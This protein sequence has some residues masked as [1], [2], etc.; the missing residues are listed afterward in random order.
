MRDKRRGGLLEER[1]HAHTDRDGDVG[2][3][4]RR[5]LPN[6][7]LDL[8]HSRT[9][10][11]DRSPEYFLTHPRTLACFADAL[12]Q[13]LPV[14]SAHVCDYRTH[15]AAKQEGERNP[16]TAPLRM[17]CSAV[18]LGRITSAAACC[19]LRAQAHERR[20]HDPGGADYPLLPR[21]PH[22]RPLGFTE[23]DKAG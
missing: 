18:E 15:P 3:F 4:E 23:R 11:T 6:A 21:P 22:R 17:M 13:H 20:A 10:Q 12:T 9:I 14:D 8:V 5:N 16:R 7:P 1:R 2:Q 19:R